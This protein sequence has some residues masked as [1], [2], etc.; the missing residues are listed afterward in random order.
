[1]TL[2][3]H[4]KDALKYTT[5]S[6]SQRSSELIRSP[7]RCSTFNHKMASAI[8]YV[9]FPFF[10]F[11]NKLSLVSMAKKPTGF[12]IQIEQILGKNVDKI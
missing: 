5:S 7:F 1:M 4:H 12:P 10:F 2:T 3:T 6:Y 11:L 9:Q 8:K